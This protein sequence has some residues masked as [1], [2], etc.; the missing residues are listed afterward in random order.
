MTSPSAFTSRIPPPALP[1][2]LPEPSSPGSTQSRRQRSR[3][4][5]GRTST[6]VDDSGSEVEQFTDYETESRASFTAPRPLTD[7][8]PGGGT[9][10]TVSGRFASTFMRVG[11]SLMS[12]SVSNSEHHSQN[13]PFGT[14]DANGASGRKHSAP[15]VTST[16][17]DAELEAEAL[18]EKERSRMEAER[19]LTMEAEERRHMEE[20]IL[21]M[22]RPTTES[23]RSSDPHE[24]PASAIAPPLTPKREEGTGGW[25]GLMKK[26]TP[27]KDL[28][29]AQ[30]IINET[31]AKEKERDKERKREDKDR[32]KERG[33][34]WPSTAKAKLSDPTYLSLSTAGGGSIHSPSSSPTGMRLGP[35]HS[36]GA[37]TPFGSPRQTL[38]SQ[39]GFA[40]TPVTPTSNRPRTPTHG[41]PGSSPILS[42]TSNEP[43]PIYAVFTPSGSLD[44]PGTLITVTRRFEK[45]EKWAV[46]HVR[47]L[48]ERMKD[49]EK[50]V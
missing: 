7:K 36:P 47:A 18:K 17:T 21:A 44:L 8:I 11:S 48:E 50:Y 23:Y 9:T 13:S 10:P 40:P 5:L 26:L 15:S 28:T 35:A 14:S 39:N 22:R 3:S 20:K 30:Q 1:L 16:L 6:T 32:E 46:G 41:P 34:E 25:L 31:K 24:L 42:S 38:T 4:P 27:T 37:Y 49:V 29:P 12:S 43:P 45:L 33:H 19:I 2:G